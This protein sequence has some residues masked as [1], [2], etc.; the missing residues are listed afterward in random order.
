MGPNIYPR[1]GPQCKEPAALTAATP[2]HYIRGQ[3]LLAVG[4]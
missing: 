3:T 1:A 2:P 4:Q